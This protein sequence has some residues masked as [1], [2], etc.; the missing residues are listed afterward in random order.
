MNR[1]SLAG[2]SPAPLLSIDVVSFD[3]VDELDVVGPLEVFRRAATRGAALR[4]A[5]VTRTQ[6]QT[7][8]GA[9]GVGMRVDA[10]FEP[11]R[12]DVLVVPGGGWAARAATGAWAEVQRGDWPALLREASS[13]TNLLAGVCTGT[14]L[15]ARAGLIGARRATTHHAALT[16]LAATGA[17]VLT[18]RVVDDGDLITCGGVTSGIDLA[19]WLVERECGGGVADDV[20]AAIAHTRTR[21]RAR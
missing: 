6:Q 14:M 20:A 19:L 9:H 17:T 15:L 13:T 10:V 12:A 7:V 1:S 11:G 2:R 18:D 5:L 8:R 4:T 16:D 21:P 3:G